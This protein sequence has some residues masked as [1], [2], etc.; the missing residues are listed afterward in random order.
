MA[1][2]VKRKEK[3]NDANTEDEIQSNS[4]DTNEK[5]VT[6]TED[7]IDN[8]AE[9]SPKK[10][11]K[12]RK[13]TDG[14][15]I[16]PGLP[17]EDEIRECNKPENKKATV[18]KREKKRQKLNDLKAQQ[19][20]ESEVVAQQKNLNYLSLWK[21]SQADWK[22]EKIRQ[23][24][25]HKHMFEKELVPKEHWKTL[26]EYF[27]GAKGQIRQTIIKEC[28]DIVEKYDNSTEEDNEITEVKFKRA[29]DML[30]SLEE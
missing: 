8:S 28:T 13:N 14:V 30:Q 2:K 1:K 3:Q 21:H 15:V 10:K 11:N 19:K 26:V 16:K 27:S 25:L 12:K 6:F 5:R 29:R 17:T 24:W 7:T 18:S 22:F 9:P 20:I 4:E 23:A